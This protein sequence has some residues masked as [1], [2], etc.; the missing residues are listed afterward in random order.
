M[1]TAEPPCG[2]AEISATLGVAVG[3]IG[4]LRARWLAWPRRSPHLAAYADIQ[5]KDHEQAGEVAVVTNGWDDEELLA[6]LKQALSDR[7]AVPPELVE[8]GKNAFAW[9]NID[10]ELAQLTYDSTRGADH[11]ASTRA[12]PAAVR[13]LTFTSPRFTIELEVTEDSLLG[14]VLPPS[15]ATI[16]VQAHTGAGRAVHAEEM[17]SFTI[18]PIPHS[19][20]RLRCRA[21]GIDV[22]TSWITL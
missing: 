1:L 8:A 9:H 11:L 14:Q 5:A 22:L 4:Q 2:Y 16:E 3:S 15:A 19:P 13:A 6:A 7:R 12:E 17:G 21:A 18:R 10:A 20:F